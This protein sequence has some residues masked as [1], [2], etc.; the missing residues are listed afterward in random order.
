[1]EE[2]SFLPIRG[3]AMKLRYRGVLYEYYP[4]QPEAVPQSM[5]MLCYRGV[6]YIR[7]MRSSNPRLTST[8]V[9]HSLNDSTQSD[10][11]QRSCAMHIQRMG[12]LYKLY[13]MGWRNGSLKY[14]PSLQH[15]LLSIFL[16]YR[17]GFAEGSKWRQ[18]QMKI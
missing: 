6:F 1:M 7:E 10:V 11:S 14:L 17:R 3:K 8:E 13:C 2:C 12:F 15:W 4:S 9:V 16:L 18:N 5:R